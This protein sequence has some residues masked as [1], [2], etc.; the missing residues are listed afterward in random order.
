[1]SDKHLLIC[2]DCREYQWLE[3]YELPGFFERHSGHKIMMFHDDGI[4]E[5][6]AF[7]KSLD[8]LLILFEPKDRRAH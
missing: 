3:L 7:N 1:M 4:G 2:V 6:E 5:I 8:T